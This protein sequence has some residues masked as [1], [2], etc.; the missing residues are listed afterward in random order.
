MAKDRAVTAVVGRFDP[1]VGHGLTH[2]LD[3]DP[4]V[5]VIASGLEYA[6]LE[7][8]VVDRAP[9]VAVLDETA[10][11]FAPTRLRSL[12]PATGVIVIAH[13]PSQAYGMS[14]LTSG[15]TCLARSASE[16][17]ILAAIHFTAQGGRLFVSVDG[18]R[19]ERRYPNDACLL[20]PRETEILEHLSVGRSNPEIARA[21]QIGAETVHTHVAHI[22]QKLKVQSKRDLIGI[23]ILGRPRVGLVSL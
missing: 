2:V 6:E 20:T 14:L 3:S 16:A 1:L 21:L 9:E 19:A 5:H 4:R 10:E 22:R 23:P 13:N 8:T 12:Q 11:P 7:R 17:D 18:E 15:A